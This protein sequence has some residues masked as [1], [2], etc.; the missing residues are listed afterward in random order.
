MSPLPPPF[1]STLLGR[2]SDLQA[3][4]F[5]PGSEADAAGGRGRGAAA[6]SSPIA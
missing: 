5:A 6:G 4:V 3:Q 2:A 1:S